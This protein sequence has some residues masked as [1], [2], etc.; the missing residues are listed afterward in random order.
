MSNLILRFRRGIAGFAGLALTLGILGATS[1][2]SQAADNGTTLFEQS[3]LNSTLTEGASVHLPSVAPG[4]TNAACLTASSTMTVPSGLIPGCANPPLD[5]DGDGAL[6]L[7]TAGVGNQIG[8]VYSSVG[9]PSSSGIDFTF[10]VHMY[11]G[12][13]ADGLAFTLAA[14]NP[15]TQELPATT[16][17]AGGGLGYTLERNIPRTGM[18]HG[19]LGI[20]FDVFGNY[21]HWLNQSASCPVMSWA[22]GS[23][24]QSVVV[25]GPG[26]MTTGYCVLNSSRNPANPGG[27]QA[28]QLNRAS[29]TGA[30]REGSKVPVR[31][32][33]NPS[34]AEITNKDGDAVAARSYLVSYVALNSATKRFLTG[35]LPDAS[36]Y[37]DADWLDDNGIP[38]Q[39]AVGWSGSTGGQ[40]QTSEIT[41]SVSTSITP[42]TSL[43]IAQ[44]Y[45][46]SIGDTTGTARGVVRVSSRVG[47]DAPLTSTARITGTVPVNMRITDSAQSGWTCTVDTNERDYSCEST[48]NS[49]PAGAE[50]ADV[51]FAVEL[52]NPATRESIQSTAV[53]R[54]FSQDAMS[55]FNDEP[56]VKAVTATASSPNVGPEN[57]GTPFTI[58]G[59]GLDGSTVSIGGADC[60]GVAISADQ[61]TLT[62]TTTS[63][64][65]GLVD[66]VVTT[67]FSVITL[68]DAFTYEA[69]PTPEPTPTPTPTPEPTPT[70]S[71]T[72]TYS[73]PPSGPPVV[74]HP[75]KN[76]QHFRKGSPPKR[77]KPRGITVLNKHRAKTREGR[78]MKARVTVRQTR[79]EVRCFK[80]IRGKQRKLSIRTYGQC[81]F[82][83]TVTYS[84]PGNSKLFY[85]KSAKKYRVRR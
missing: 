72:P 79:G 52:T 77:I 61:T 35:A 74:P 76:P 5:I 37:A 49:F 44:E 64:V 30:T 56:T 47:P 33:I 48:D 71:P 55:G 68:S 26:N 24:P 83:L 32:T 39:F 75:A 60:T 53:S 21:S 4:D 31:V 1:S 82:R 27:A 7:T 12:S 8:S 50:L 73:P 17:I 85:F 51:T 66:V 6:R 46:G 2:P 38:R 25:R 10:N 20:G 36:G 81:S 43:H 13:S 41:R 34:D 65:P 19:Y 40:N 15:N 45:H 29:G 69:T 3:F 9:I 16:G 11:G 78:P 57:G 23:A 54:V 84:A 70:P 67:P 59:E 28:L 63:H 42:A 18:P 62:C 80:I 58:T 14:V 22:N